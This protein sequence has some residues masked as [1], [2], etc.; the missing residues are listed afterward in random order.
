MKVGELMDKKE[1]QKNRVM[2]YFIDAADEIIREEGIQAV[3]IRRVSDMAGFNSATLYNYFENLDHL[4]FLASMKTVKE[5][6]QQVL[7]YI[8][9][10]KNIIEKNLLIWECFC[11]LSFRRPKIYYRVFFPKL[12]RSTDK[13]VQEY[14]RVYPKDQ[15]ELDGVIPDLLQAT[16]L[17]MRN[18]KILEEGIAAGWFDEENHEEI[19][20]MTMLIYKGMLMRVMDSQEEID[21]EDAVNKTVK[22]VSNIYAIYRKK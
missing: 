12:N 19:N 18:H 5:Y 1:I 2:S 22:Y 20:D 17:N 7:D 21:L 13:Y 11:K 10:A 15:V 4:L 14:Y 6:P 16:D 8:K 9:D 3:T